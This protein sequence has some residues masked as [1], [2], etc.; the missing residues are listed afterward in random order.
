M[1]LIIANGENAVGGFG[2]TQST[3]QELLN[4]GVDVITSGNHIWDQK[5]MMPLLDGEGPLSWPPGRQ[6]PEAHFHA[7]ADQRSLSSHGQ[8]VGRLHGAATHCHCR[9]SR[10]SHLGEGR[11]GLALGL[12]CQRRLVGTHTHVDTI[13]TRTLPK[14]TAFVSDL[15]MCAVIDSI[16]GDDS[17]AILQRYLTGISIR[18]DREVYL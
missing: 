13:D 15:G 18:L 8:T 3:A 2:I 1:D 16:I 10:G 5:E 17:D 7:C 14:G 11:P 12:S 9:L 4:T 6:P